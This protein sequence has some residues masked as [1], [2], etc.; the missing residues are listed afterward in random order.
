[1][2]TLEYVAGLF[3][4]EGHLG[5]S[6][7]KDS[8]QVDITI[9]NTSLPVLLELQKHVGGTVVTLKRYRRQ[10]RPVHTWELSARPAEALVRQLLPHFHIKGSEALAWLRFIELRQRLDRERKARPR[11]GRIPASYTADEVGQI[12]TARAAVLAFRTAHP[13][14]KTGTTA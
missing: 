14:R 12:E 3:D 5:L 10:H 9:T 2:L 13:W 4:G 7:D 8:Y 1:M 6:S 11:P